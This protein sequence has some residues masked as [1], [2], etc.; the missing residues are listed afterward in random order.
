MNELCDYLERSVKGSGNN[1]KVNLDIKNY[2]LSIDTVIPLGLIINETITNALKYGIA[3]VR[4]GEIHVS[5]ERI[6]DN[7]YKMYLGDN[8]IGYSEEINPKT[9]NSL[10]LKLIYIGFYM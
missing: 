10:G 2:K 6:A 8:G 1:V 3:E 9:S 5:V 7:R 4:D